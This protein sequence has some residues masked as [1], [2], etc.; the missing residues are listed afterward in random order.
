MGMN[1]ELNALAADILSEI[2]MDIKATAD[3]VHRRVHETLCMRRNRYANITI[4][5]LQSLDPTEL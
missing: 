1:N 2:I 4:T 3:D 5:L